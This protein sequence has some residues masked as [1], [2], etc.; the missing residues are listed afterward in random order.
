MLGF[1]FAFVLAAGVFYVLSPVLGLPLIV[2]VIA[3]VVI[4]LAAVPRRGY[5]ARRRAS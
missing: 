5:P 3:A 1:F 2:G 4:V